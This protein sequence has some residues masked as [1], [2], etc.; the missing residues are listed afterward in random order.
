MARQP[1]D[2]EMYYR[3]EWDAGKR[4]HRCSLETCT[5]KGW[6]MAYEAR[7]CPRCGD[8]PIEEDL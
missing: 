8:A 6:W 1:D 5:W 3:R 2:V 7:L 4:R